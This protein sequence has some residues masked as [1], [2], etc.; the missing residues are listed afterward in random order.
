MTTERT[1]YSVN[2]RRNEADAYRRFLHEN[3]FYFETSAYVDD[4]IHFEIKLSA[5]E[6]I[7]ADN[8]LQTI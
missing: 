4:I 3:Q 8:F 1:F 7:I 5:D 2:L 6:V